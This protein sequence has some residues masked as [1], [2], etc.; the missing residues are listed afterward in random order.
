MMAEVKK[1][2]IPEP[3]ER[4]GKAFREAG[5]ELYL[6]GGY[7]RDA[8]LGKVHKNADATTDAH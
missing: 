1:L 5:H 7:V 3:L 4:L 6:V 8:L 2:Y